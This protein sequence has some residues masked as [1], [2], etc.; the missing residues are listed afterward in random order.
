MLD[1]L[2]EDLIL[3]IAKKIKN[4]NHL[5][6]KL[7]YL[8]SKTYYLIEKKREKYDMIV[9]HKR[10]MKYRETNYYSYDNV[11]VH[12]RYKKDTP[13]NNNDLETIA[14]DKNIKS[15][16]LYIESYTE[17]IPQYVLNKVTTVK[18]NFVE[19]GISGGLPS[20]KKFLA[21]LPNITSFTCGIE[22]RVDD[23]MFQNN[24]KITSVSATGCLRSENLSF[25]KNL[26]HLSYLYIDSSDLVDISDIHRC[27]KLHTINIR[28]C[29]KLT[30]ISVLGE[31][32]NLKTL[33]IKNGTRITNIDCL[34]KINLITAHLY[35]PNIQDYSSLKNVRNIVLY[36]EDLTILKRQAEYLTSVYRLTIY[37]KY[38][39]PI[40]P[41]LGDDYIAVDE[42]IPPLIGRVHYN[43]FVYG[44]INKNRALYP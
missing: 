4:D 3:D 7:R 13:E 43:S 38:V 12:F 26:A 2:P 32:P 40:D 19:D 30:D 44:L 24:K 35:C 28:N 14:N 10:Y 27:K 36:I 6:T 25:L 33:L 22:L 5:L 42:D 1:N 15:I 8:S 39:C 16:D 17:N 11:Q 18:I 23:V 41:I 31:L 21:K 20:I 37:K 29:Y 34:S 9:D